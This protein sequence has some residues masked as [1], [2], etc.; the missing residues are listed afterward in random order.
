MFSFPILLTCIY[1][2]FSFT[3]LSGSTLFL[4]PKHS[5]PHHMHQDSTPFHH[6]YT[7]SPLHTTMDDE[8]SSSLQLGE[9]IIF[10]SEHILA[11]RWFYQDV[12]SVH[13]L[14]LLRRWFRP[15]VGSI[16]TLVPSTR[17]FY[18][19][20]GSVHTLVLLRRWFRPH[21]GFI[22]T[23]VQN[24]RCLWNELLDANCLI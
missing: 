20:V 19:D 11:T 15:H 4:I 5:S 13:T 1:F 14:V 2:I 18:W 3:Q 17:W 10:Q 22:E 23:L 12:G 7:R 6:L 9:K 21:V 8:T 24:G 16:E